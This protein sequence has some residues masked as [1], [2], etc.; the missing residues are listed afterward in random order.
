MN[1]T[2]KQFASQADLEAKKISFIKLSD[3]AYAYT[4]EGD[5]NSGVII[6]DD[7]V[8]VIDTTATPLMAKDLIRR[9]RGVTDKPI[10]YVVLSHYHAV[11]V[12]GASAYFDEGAEQIIASRGTY[13]MIVERGAQD[14]QSEIER[15]PRLFSG[16]ESVPGLTWPTMVFEKELTIFMGKLEVKLQHIGMGHT[17]GDTIAWIPSQKIC[18]SGDLVEYD[19]AAYTGD[20]QLEEWPATLEALRAMHAE[21]LV[22]GRGP[23]L[24]T[25]AEVNKGLD[26]TRDFVTCL[27]Q[28][29]KEAVAAGMNLK[30]AMAH[31]RKTMDPRFGHVFIY[32]HCLPFDVTRAVDEAQGIKHP[33]IWTA[34]RD[35]EMWHG[36][37]AE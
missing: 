33:R 5:P 14:M 16:V 25:P 1:T 24:L 27:L 22:P 6:G 26:Y 18:F 19:A 15:F 28:S 37:Q 23:A 21:K 32:E 35:Q 17:K 11:R 12:L 10:K 20:A 13:E 30:Q 2:N 4:A 29:A 7:S 9:I 36:L 8:M 31:T 34:E 3:N